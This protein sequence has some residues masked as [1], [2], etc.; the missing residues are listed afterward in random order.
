MDLRHLR[1]FQAVAEELSFS[2][3]ARRLRIAQP[4]LSRAVQE[5]ERELGAGLLDRT[6][7]SVRLT[8]A[9]AVLLEEI[10]LLLDRFEESLRRVRRTAAG[11]EGELRLGYIGPPTRPFLGRLLAE[12]RRRYPRVSVHDAI[13]AACREAGFAPRVQHSPSLIGTVLQYVEAGA[14]I[15]VVPEGIVSEPKESML[16]LVPLT[17]T[18]TVSL[19]M[20]WNQ[21]REDPPTV[22][23]RSLV[24]EWLEHGKLWPPGRSR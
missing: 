17:P 15:G 19:V 21:D 22:A 10:G 20:L 6:R 3:A 2:R 1:Y 12:Y 23:F 5:V 16:E 14:G 4:A 7:R 11:E 8:P 24:T 9:G 18:H 13:L